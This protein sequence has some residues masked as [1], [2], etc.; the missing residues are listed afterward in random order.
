MG[1]GQLANANLR[2]QICTSTFLGQTGPAG[3]G[4]AVEGGLLQQGLPGTEEQVL[5][6]IGLDSKDL[7]AYQMAGS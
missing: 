2:C 7:P 6:T 1:L 4:T 5:Q 3:R